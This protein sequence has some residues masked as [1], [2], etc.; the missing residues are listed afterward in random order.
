MSLSRSRFLV[1]I[2]NACDDLVR[3]GIAWMRPA[4]PCLAYPS[5]HL[6]CH[7]TFVVN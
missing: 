7:T 6:I 3:L 5:K 4:G 1:G 2:W